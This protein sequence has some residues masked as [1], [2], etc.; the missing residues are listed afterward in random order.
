M[1]LKIVELP[2]GLDCHRVDSLEDAEVCLMFPPADF[3]EL[4]QQLKKL[5]KVQIRQKGALRAE[6][7]IGLLYGDSSCGN[8][9][10][11]DRLDFTV[12]GPSVNLTSR[13]ERLCKKALVLAMEDFVKFESGEGAWT[14]QGEHSV[15]KVVA[16]H[17]SVYKLEH[18]E[19]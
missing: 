11:P 19:K 18:F 3:L 16:D 10:A 6:V 7:G 9:G 4:Q 2:L 8:V 15:V 17:V 13:G 5:S 12:I 14:R 1:I